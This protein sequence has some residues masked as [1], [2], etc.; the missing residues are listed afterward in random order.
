MGAHAGSGFGLSGQAAARY[1]AAAAAAGLEAGEGRRPQMR[2]DASRFALLKSKS[3]NAS[4]DGDSEANPAE[5]SVGNPKPAANAPAAENA[6]R[7]ASLVA[8]PASARR[9]LPLAHTETA[10]EGAQGAH[11]GEPARRSIL[12]QPAHAQPA[13]LLSALPSFAIQSHAMSGAREREIAETVA[14]A[15]AEAQAALALLSDEVQQLSQMCEATIAALV[16]N[17][18]S[19]LA[20]D[21]DEATAAATDAAIESAITAAADNA[22]WTARENALLAHTAA[23]GAL[24]DKAPTLAIAKQLQTQVLG[25]LAQ[26]ETVAT[27]RATALSTAEA[28]RERIQ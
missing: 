5:Q 8:K 20:G 23:A 14:A 3:K 25:A 16:Q 10:A 21:A 2:R 19:E 28:L 22:A 12:P 1:L 9:L 18:P 7:L 11:G 26:F 4:G 17:A 6:V 13:P 15:A 24:M 27:R